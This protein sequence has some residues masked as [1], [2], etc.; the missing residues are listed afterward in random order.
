MPKESRKKPTHTS[1]LSGP[2][3]RSRARKERMGIAAKVST[4]FLT[5]DP[6]KVEKVKTVHE[7]FG[8]WKHKN[9]N[10]SVS[11]KGKYL[12]TTVRLKAGQHVLTEYPVAVGDCNES[13]AKQIVDDSRFLHLYPLLESKEEKMDLEHAIKVVTS[14]CWLINRKVDDV[15][16]YLHISMINHS[17]VPNVCFS[18]GS[19]FTIRDIEVGEELTCSYLKPSKLGGLSALERSKEMQHWFPCCY[20]SSCKDDKNFSVKEMKEHH[21][22]IKG[23]APKFAKQKLEFW[24]EEFS[25]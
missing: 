19:V 15:A 8:W 3:T 9:L 23:K 10:V 24:G 11:E 5:Q 12:F 22:W 6:A 18:D 7:T 13:V 16:I 25:S 1:P 4:T 20:C 2:M 14:N 17:C 21:S